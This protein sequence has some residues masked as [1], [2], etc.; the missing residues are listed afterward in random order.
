MITKAKRNNKL[1]FSDMKTKVLKDKI[2]LHNFVTA[3]IT[4]SQ[5]SLELQSWLLQSL[6]TRMEHFLTSRKQ[7]QFLARSIT[8]SIQFTEF[9]TVSWR[10]RCSTVNIIS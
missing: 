1:T 9:F 4:Y 7:N 3:F 2:I 10:Y 5:R 6:T 8:T